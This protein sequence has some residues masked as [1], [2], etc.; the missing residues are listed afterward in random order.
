MI[1]PNRSF[2]VPGTVLCRFILCEAPGRRS[3]SLSGEVL[4][5]LLVHRVIVWLPGAET[6]H[7]AVVHAKGSGDQHRIVNLLVRRAQRPRGFDILSRNML[8]AL[9]NLSRN[10]EET[11][12]LF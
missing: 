4:P 10:N 7:I 12:E 1:L 6:I 8:A 3:V 11:L 2:L 5:H 9:L